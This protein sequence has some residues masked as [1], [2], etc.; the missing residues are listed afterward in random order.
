VNEVSEVS[1]RQQGTR[2]TVGG[3]SDGLSQQILSSMLFKPIKAK[4]R[5]YIFQKKKKKNTKK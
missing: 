4:W 1:E 5:R 2:K 3:L